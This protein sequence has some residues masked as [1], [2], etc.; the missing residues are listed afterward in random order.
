MFSRMFK[1]KIIYLKAKEL[2]EHFKI[3]SK[4]L[5]EI[6]ELLK[7]ATK[8]EDKGWKATKLGISKGAKDGVYMGVNYIRWDSKIKKDIG[9]INAVK[10]FKNSIKINTKQTKIIHSNKEKGDEYEIFIA[11]HFREQGYTIAEHGIDNGVKD[12][13]IDII[14]KKDKDILF[15]QCKNWS[16]NHKI[17]VKD[18]EIKVT[19]QDVQDYK[20]KHPLYTMYKT[21]IIYIM[22][23]NVLHGSGYHYIQNNSDVIEFRIIPIVG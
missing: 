11:K 10:G 9:F 4:Q 17:K 18:K 22:S 19:R 12:H 2:R 21:K 3:T 7:W 16:V 8:S 23:E 13:G 20:E 15:I 1:K 5:H 6:L 14:A